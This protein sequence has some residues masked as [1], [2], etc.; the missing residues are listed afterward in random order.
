M[1]DKYAKS[2]SVLSLEKALGD[3]LSVEPM[4]TRNGKGQL[5][6]HV[7]HHCQNGTKFLSF[8]T[9]V[10]AKIGNQLYVSD[11]HD[12]SETTAFHCK[13]YTGMTLVERRAKIYDGTIIHINTES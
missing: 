4:L 10:A 13:R 9:L 8:G 1:Q 5:K 6:S 7:V 3:T 11:Y 2:I 12:F